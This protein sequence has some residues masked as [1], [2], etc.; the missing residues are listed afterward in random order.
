[1][2]DRWIPISGSFLFKPH[3]N[4]LFRGE[5]ITWEDGKQ[6]ASTGIAIC[7]KRF[8]GGKI[9]ADVTF[10]K[11]SDSSACDIV[12]W[13]QPETR[14]FVSAGLAK[15]AMFGIRHFDTK[16]TVHAHAGDGSNLEINRRYK[17]QVHLRAS[18]AVLTVD[19]VDSVAATL[20]FNLTPS[21]VGIFCRDINE[22]RISNFTVESEVPRVFVVTE[23]KSPFNEIYQEVVK[24][25]CKEFGL[26]AVRADETYGPGLIIADI[27]RQ[28]DEAKFVIAEIT[29]P[30]PNVYYEVGYARSKNKPT[31]LLADKRIEKLPFDVSPF[32]TLFYENTIDGKGKVEEA[33]RR[34]IQAIL[35][36]SGF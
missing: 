13:Y 36:Q 14:Y 27:E 25:V 2:S 6:G 31:I 12:F 28:I 15:E 7:E 23:F 16:W 1:M 19:G 20:P 10:T 9:S 5:P 29:P 33:L 4:I 22:I 17:L 11:L 35:S 32:R 18:R 21:Q 34:H 30:N 26:E 24:V 3:S 8:A